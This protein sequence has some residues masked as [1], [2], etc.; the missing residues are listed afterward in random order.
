MTGGRGTLS[1][2]APLPQKVCSPL[3]NGCPAATAGWSYLVPGPN[4]LLSSCLTCCSTLP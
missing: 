3:Q 2:A 4:M 1:A